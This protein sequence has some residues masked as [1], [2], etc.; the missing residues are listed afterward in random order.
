[1][2]VRT[3]KI[4]EMKIT[5][6]RPRR[7]FNGSESQQPSQIFSL[8]LTQPQRR[9]VSEL[10][11]ALTARLK[12]DAP[13]QRVIAVSQAELQEI[14]DKAVVH[15]RVVLSSGREADYYVDL[16]RITLD[17][18]AAPLVG[19]VMLGSASRWRR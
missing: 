14:K 18:E 3:Q 16:R 19:E 13:N 6:R 7:R 4:A 2:G 12:L 11:P 9:V 8:R 10:V 1:M 17:A 15:G 5:P